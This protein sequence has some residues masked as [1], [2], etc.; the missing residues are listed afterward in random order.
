MTL[1]WEDPQFLVPHMQTALLKKLQ[2]YPYRT[3]KTVGL[4]LHF[5]EREI[6]VKRKNKDLKIRDQRDEKTIMSIL[7]ILSKKITKLLRL[8][9][10]LL[11]REL[12]YK[13]AP[14]GR[15]RKNRKLLYSRTLR[16]FGNNFQLTIA[17]FIILEDVI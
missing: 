4:I 10:F 11:H 12:F 2:Q 17:L 16:P 14:L 7:F 9:F 5:G 1:S 3:A 13:L 15:L 6:E 8:R